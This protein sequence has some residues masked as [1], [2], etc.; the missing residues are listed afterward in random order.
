VAFWS[1][2]QM[3]K[4][5]DCKSIMCWFKSSPDLWA[6]IL[7]RPTRADCKSADFS[8]RG[9]KSLFS[10][11]RYMIDSSVAQLVEQRAVNSRVT[12]SNP[13]GGVFGTVAQWQRRLIQ[14]QKSVGSSPTSATGMTI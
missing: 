9:F 6:R 1:G 12:G 2:T 3:A 8:L 13:V 10:H 11:C 4:R 14:N 5:M 7:K